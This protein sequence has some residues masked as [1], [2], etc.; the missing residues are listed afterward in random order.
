LRFVAEF[1]VEVLR[2]GKSSGD[3][4]SDHPSVRVSQR[5]QRQAAG[6]RRGELVLVRR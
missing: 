1:Q 5:T 3:R 4:S 6:E 2:E